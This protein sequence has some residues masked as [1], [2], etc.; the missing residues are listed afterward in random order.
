MRQISRNHPWFTKDQDALED[1]LALE[2]ERADFEEHK[3][4]EEEM[5][6]NQADL[7]AKLE[8]QRANKLRKYLIISWVFFVSYVYLQGLPVGFGQC[9]LVFCVSSS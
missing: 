4:N 8:E 7:R 2:Q 3:A 9:G 6:A 5:R 1:V